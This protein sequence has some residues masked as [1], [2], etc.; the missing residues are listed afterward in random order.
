MRNS[1]KS[2]SIQ[3][4]QST[5]TTFLKNIHYIFCVFSTYCKRRDVL[6]IFIGSVLL[7]ASQI[8]RRRGTA[9]VF[10]K[11]RQNAGEEVIVVIL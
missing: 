11:T 7:L 4:E 10:P 5:T 1:A 9:T 3:R 8:A 6:A 2:A